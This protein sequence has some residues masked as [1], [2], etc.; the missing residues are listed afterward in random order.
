MKNLEIERKYLIKMPDEEL[1]QAFPGVQIVNITQTYTG[2][3]IRIRKW[4]EKGEVKYIKT[5]KKHL[6]NLT[7]IETECEITRD[8]YERLFSFSDP[9]RK[10]LEKIRYRL[11]FCGKLVEIDIF[12]F[13]KNQ[14]F[15]E[16]ELES[17]DEEFF[18]PDFIQTI[19][20][21]TNDPA[22]RNHSLAQNIPKE[23]KF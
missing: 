23:E 21:V 19:K 10:P 5:V 20:E 8:E 16:V 4:E 11:P 6:T 12:P 13:W 1:L 14:A 7:R 22:Y 2:L 3:G 17:E 9:E 18:I 15:L